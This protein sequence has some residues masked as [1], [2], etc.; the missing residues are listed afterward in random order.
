VTDN[1]TKPMIGKAALGWWSA[2]QPDPDRKAKTKGDSGALARLRRAGIDA[3]ATEEVTFNLYCRLEPAAPFRGTK[4]LERAA[5]IAAVLAHVREHDPRKV[6]MAAGEKSGDDQ[7]VLQPL[8]LRRLLAARSPDESLV[9]FRRLV[10]LL[11][12]TANVADLANCLFD[13]P[14]EL[15]GDSRRTRFAFDYYGAGAAAPRD[16]EEAAA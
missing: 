5:L 14:D 3:A 13:W 12:H 6:A 7:R 15:R 10:A 9:A 4:L 2:L 11:G 16:T 1:E 8:R